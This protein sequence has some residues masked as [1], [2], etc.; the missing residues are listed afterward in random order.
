MFNIVNKTGFKVGMAVLSDKEGREQAVAMIKGTYC[1]DAD[2]VVSLVEEQK[3]ICMSDEYFGEPGKSSIQYASDVALR[4][5]GTNISLVG[6]AYTYNDRTSQIDAGISVGGLKKTVR[7]F[8]NRF[9]KYSFGMVSMSK[10]EPFEKMPLQYERAF[11]GEDK[12]HPKE[13]KHA[14]EKRNP[15]GTG[16]RVNKTKEAINNLPLPNIE[17][18]SKQIKSWKDKPSPTGFGSISS[19][20]EPRLGFAGTYD[21][22]WEENTMPLLPDDFDDKFFDSANPDL[23]FKNFLQG[24]ETVELYNLHPERQEVKFKLPQNLMKVSFYIK[25]DIIDVPADLDTIVFEPDDNC[26]TLLWRAS[27]DC[28]KKV[29]YL[30]H[31][32]IN[33]EEV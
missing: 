20:W 27:A 26:F 11:G 18:T 17:L 32:T 19:S 9:W 6:H 8:G 7:V 14:F 1:F 13:S 29:L 12:T 2:G 22:A 15:I 21:E 31:I 30:E 24:G 3:D 23:I 25:D 33:C 28:F 4:K 10:A 5:G 16:F